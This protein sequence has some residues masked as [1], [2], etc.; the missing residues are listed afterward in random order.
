[1]ACMMADGSEPVARRIVLLKNIAEDIYELFKK[2]QR[3]KGFAFSPDTDAQLT[4]EMGF[5]FKETPDQLR[6]LVDVKRD[7]ESDMPM[8]RLV[9]GDVGFGKTE[10]ILRA[11]VKA[12]LGLEAGD[13]VGASTPFYVTNITIRSKRVA[14]V[15]Y[16]QWIAC[17]VMRTLG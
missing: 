2:R 6:A 15:E 9:C 3:V 10:I 4:F 8:D 17:L 11:A 13:G 12:A 7:M 16:C 5:P 14:M 1:M